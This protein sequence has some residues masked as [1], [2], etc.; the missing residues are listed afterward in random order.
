MCYAKPGPRCSAYA[1]KKMK[2]A[3]ERF[4]SEPYRS[5]EKFSMYEAF[6][7]AQE[8]FFETPD[9]QEFLN[10]QI[11][12]TGDPGGI[13]SVM[14]ED[15][16]SKRQ[17]KLQQLKQSDS[18]DITGKHGYI[19]VYDNVNRLTVLRTIENRRRKDR[20][21]AER[22]LTLTTDRW[23]NAPDEERPSLE[24]DLRQAQQE[25]IDA[26]AVW[27]LAFDDVDVIEER[28]GE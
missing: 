18:G 19:D 27:S 16:W 22:M 7:H 25:Y 9:G 15:A 4:D 5:P 8:E 26:H 14:G 2:D 1:R 12:Q 11:I 3:F 13:L 20:D 6:R 21:K 24:K 17:W 23:E 28:E 10:D